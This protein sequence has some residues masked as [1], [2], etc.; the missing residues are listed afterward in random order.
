[1]KIDSLTFGNNIPKNTFCTYCKKE[2]ITHLKGNMR[3]MTNVKNLYFEI[4]FIDPCEKKYNKF[5]I[6][7]SDV[8]SYT[9]FRNICT[10]KKWSVNE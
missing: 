10:Y 9:G 7:S 6:D 4:S 3:E 8:N 5:R 2:I 1:L